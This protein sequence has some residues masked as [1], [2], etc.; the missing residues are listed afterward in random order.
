MSTL[1]EVEE[2]ARALPPE[3]KAQLFRFLA[4][5]FAFP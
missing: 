1:T 3:Q 5:Q 4:A 2:A